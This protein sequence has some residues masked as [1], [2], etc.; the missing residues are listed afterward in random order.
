LDLDAIAELKTQLKTYFT[1]T[2][3]GKAKQVVGLELERDKGLSTLKLT[4]AQY[5]KRVLEHFGMADSKPVSTPLDP[6][7][8]LHKLPDEEHH[9]IP[10]YCCAIGSLMYAAMA[11]SPIFLLQSKRLVNS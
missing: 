7:I 8:A 4:Q 2:D 5:T 3:L 10:E 6:N 9:D 1:I 11:H